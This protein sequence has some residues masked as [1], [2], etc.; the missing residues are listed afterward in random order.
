LQA[1]RYYTIGR[2]HSRRAEWDDAIP[3]YKK[4]I[5]EDS[6]FAIAYT[7]LGSIHND[8]G[9][10]ADAIKF[11]SLAMKWAEKLTDRERYYVV[12]E[13]YRHRREL[14]KA[15][16]NYKIL[17]QLYPDSF[18]GHNNLA[19]IYQF[20]RQYEEALEH[21]QELA[22]LSPNTWYVHHS[23]G[24][25]YGGLGEVDSAVEHF[26]KALEVSPKQYWS[27]VGL[28]MAYTAN[29]EFEEAR[30]QFEKLL[31]QNE[32]WQSIG[33][34]RLVILYR[35]MGKYETAL[36]HLLTG[37]RI[38]QMLNKKSSEAWRRLVAADC[39]LRR[40]E[41]EGYFREITMA[42]E[43][44]PSAWVLGSSGTE[45]ARNRMFDRAENVLRR[46]ET[47]ISEEHTNP[48]LAQFY[49]LKGE[50]EFAK[51]N[52]QESANDYQ[53]S[54][55]YDDG[56]QTRASLARVYVKTGNYEKAIEEHEFIVAHRWATL[57]D[58]V[59]TLWA[60]SHY[61]LGE[62]Y[63]LKGDT[64]KAIRYYEKFLNIFKQAD[65]DLQEVIDAKTRLAELKGMS[66]K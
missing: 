41:K 61:G 27:N 3:F 35:Y 51:Q 5:E 13:Y 40:G 43:A 65:E 12:A 33:E 50:I 25:N 19:F 21:L 54:I 53:M 59:P 29:G 37:I 8:M 17:V 23:M 4:A 63:E 2:E 48:N 44:W 11:S 16:E 31:E 39:Y 36:T 58:A 57:F 1:L 55:S 24:L 62:I 28:G 30:K 49:R 34:S 20:T 60:L 15:I 6:T 22:R 46:L 18:T 66:L 52:Y 64:T 32:S 7:R 9:K 38:D 42:V 10:A 45:Y 26:S 56:L 47:L 14:D